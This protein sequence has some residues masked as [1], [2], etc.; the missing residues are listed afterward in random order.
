MEDITPECKYVD[1]IPE[2]NVSEYKTAFLVCLNQL[3][4]N[5]I[6]IG[7]IDGNPENSSYLDIVAKTYD[8]SDPSVLVD[9]NSSL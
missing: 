8:T 3:F 4:N 7:T 1:S 5:A 6:S 2:D 9:Y